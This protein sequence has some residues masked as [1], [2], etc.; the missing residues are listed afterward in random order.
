MDSS[1]VKLRVVSGTDVIVL[2]FTKVPDA[3][4]AALPIMHWHATRC[5]GSPGSNLALRTVT[6]ETFTTTE[7]ASEVLNPCV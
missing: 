3:D 6:S 2:L 1:C 7:V 4:A 5:A